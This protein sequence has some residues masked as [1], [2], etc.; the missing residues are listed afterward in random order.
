M[1]EAHYYVYMCVA[2]NYIILDSNSTAI[3]QPRTMTET[4]IQNVVTHP[5][6]YFEGSQYRASS[7]MLSFL[8][9][10]NYPVPKY[11]FE[12]IIFMWHKNLHYTALCNKPPDN[13]ASL[14]GHVQ[15][16]QLHVGAMHHHLYTESTTSHFSAFDTVM[17]HFSQFMNFGSG[18][19]FYKGQ[20]KTKT[21]PLVRSA[22]SILTT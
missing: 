21:I 12:Y 10:A 16:V 17:I 19:T 9:A 22:I 4:E 14:E 13:T 8:Q 11:I 6:L 20:A 3:M 18:V 15:Y 1:V 5:Q 2:N 7:V